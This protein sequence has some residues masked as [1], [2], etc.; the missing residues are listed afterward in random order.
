MQ[1]YKKNIITAMAVIAISLGAFM[2]LGSQENVPQ[3]LNFKLTDIYG[4]KFDMGTLQGK[5]LIIDFWDTW[6]PPC[7]DSIPEFIELKEKYSDKEFEIVG[8]ALG[9]E[10]RESVKKFSIDNKINYKVL[11]ADPNTNPSLYRTYKDIRYIPT[12]FVLDKQGN[13]VK[14]LQGYVPGEEFE[15]LIKELF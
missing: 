5:V 3:N 1:N 12:A 6:C 4:E 7:R 9:R 15:K 11:I 2:N 10:G 8:I 14:R 13:I